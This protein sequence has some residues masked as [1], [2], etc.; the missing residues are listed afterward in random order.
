MSK[1]PHA[2]NHDELEHIALVS[3]QAILLPLAPTNSQTGKSCIQFNFTRGLK[4]HYIIIKK[5]LK[6]T[7][8]WSIIFQAGSMLCCLGAAAPTGFLIFLN[9]IY[10]YNT[11]LT[12]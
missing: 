12:Q 11:K 8:K 5:I 6:C 10:M 4:E 9:I 7:K 3:S 2:M 1:P